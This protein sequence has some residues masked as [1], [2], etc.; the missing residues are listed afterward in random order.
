LPALLESGGER[1]VWLVGAVW[2]RL[3]CRPAKVSILEILVERPVRCAPNDF[4]ALL[5]IRA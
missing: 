2:D 5:D 4:Y 3:V 1:G